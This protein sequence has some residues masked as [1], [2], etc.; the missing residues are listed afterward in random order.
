MSEHRQTQRGLGYFNAIYGYGMI[1]VI[2]VHTISFNSDYFYSNF[3]F[4]GWFSVLGSAYMVLFFLLSGYG[5]TPSPAR[6]AL[7]FHFRTL[8][9][10]YYITAAAVLLAKL[11]LSFVRRRSF[12]EHG[13][14][15]LLTYAL[16][17]NVEGGG[18][19]FG[20][21][22]ESVSILWF[23]LALFEAR[24]LFNCLAHLKDRRLTYGLSLACTLLG[25]CMMRFSS[26]W[27]F[28]V[29]IGLMATGWV[30]LGNLIREEHLLDKKLPLVPLL[31]LAALSLN[32]F[33]RSH[34]DLIRGELNGGL[35]DVLGLS[36]LSVLLLFFFDW[37]TARTIDT[38]G[39]RFFAAI[40]MNN[41]WII[42][43]HAFEK[44]I[45]PNY[46]FL[47]WF[48]NSIFLQTVLMFAARTAFIA[49][50]FAGL[51]T[52]RELL[53]KFRRRGR[54]KVTIEL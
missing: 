30:A 22:V 31:I 9:K 12:W 21:P 32:T 36:C 26:V 39:N 49:V 53:R 40:G 28:V 50:V 4:Y 51:Q 41:I 24:C 44:V 23:L 16:G 13:G 8:L 1:M 11:I 19:L 45:L 15:Y 14:E 33:L 37:L 35:L 48:P 7:S 29:H 17:L 2:L 10:P 3:V 27:P 18:T 38:A 43:I 52:G 42:C 34:T 54:K 20:I 25:Y 46:K 47:E 5:F 6:K